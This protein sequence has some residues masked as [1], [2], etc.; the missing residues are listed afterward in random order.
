MA[1][2]MAD[3]AEQK[4]W[5]R[6]IAEKNQTAADLGE[7]LTIIKKHKTIEGSLALARTYGEKAREALAEAPDHPFRAL[8]DELVSFAITRGS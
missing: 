4:F 6:T 2:E 1:L 8:L 3:S 7:A 5:Q